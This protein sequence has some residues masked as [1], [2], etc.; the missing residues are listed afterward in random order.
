MILYFS[1]VT[2]DATSTTKLV[3][4][5]SHTPMIFYALNKKYMY[6]EKNNKRKLENIFALRPL[7]LKDL[8]PT[9]PFFTDKPLDF[10]ENPLD[11]F[12]LNT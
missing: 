5:F 1:A 9:S 8:L 4:Q 12:H 10:P 2:K 7:D 11:L 6:A 3:S